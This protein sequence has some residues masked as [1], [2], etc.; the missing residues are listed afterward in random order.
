[1]PISNTSGVARSLLGPTPRLT[2]AVNRLV[3]KSVNRFVNRIQRPQPA[4]ASDYLCADTQKNTPPYPPTVTLNGYL[5]HIIRGFLHKTTDPGK[6]RFPPG[7]P[8]PAKR[9]AEKYP[10]L[11]SSSNMHMVTLV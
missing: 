1:M 11:P 4:T 6:T 3:N 5:R 8:Q 10:P 9:V 7:N 2:R